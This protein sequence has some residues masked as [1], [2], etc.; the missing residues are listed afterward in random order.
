MGPARSG[1]GIHTDPLGT[2]AWNALVSGR[3]RW[4]LFPP[5]TAKLSI[6]TK[7]GEDSEAISWF[8]TVYPRVTAPD[9]TGAKPIEFI[10]EAGEVVFVPGG[11]HHVVLNI[12]DTIAV[13]QN[14]ARSALIPSLVCGMMRSTS[15]LKVVW[16]RTVRGRPKLSQ[17]W[18]RAIEVCGW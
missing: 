18:K 15:N 9:W 1:T 12:T 4:V 7:R 3:K 11:W 13:T 16:P 6:K 8:H 14:F 17:R 2:S 5:S 10:Q